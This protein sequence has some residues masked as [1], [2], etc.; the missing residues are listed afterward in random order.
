MILSRF[1]DSLSVYGQMIVYDHYLKVVT[2]KYEIILY[3][4]NV[5]LKCSINYD[6]K[7][8]WILSTLQLNDI[9]YDHIV[10]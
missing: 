4:I 2:I 8:V 9:L 7:R 5:G 1:C 6:R 3:Q 10:T